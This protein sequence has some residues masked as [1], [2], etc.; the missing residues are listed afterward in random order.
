[1]VGV[2]LQPSLLK[3]FSNHHIDTIHNPEVLLSDF[4]WTLESIN[5]CFLG[6][7]SRSHYS[8]FYDLGCGGFAAAA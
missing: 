2:V 8:L 4:L 3:I 6:A 7:I 5:W 1:M